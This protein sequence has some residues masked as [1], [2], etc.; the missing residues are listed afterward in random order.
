M[1]PMFPIFSFL[2]QINALQILHCVFTDSIQQ[3]TSWTLLLSAYSY[4]P[5]LLI[6]DSQYVNY[7]LVAIP[8]PYILTSLPIQILILNLQISQL[9]LLCSDIIF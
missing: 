3:N 9:R 5:L 1:Y 8:T 7:C 6:A 4:L 2:I